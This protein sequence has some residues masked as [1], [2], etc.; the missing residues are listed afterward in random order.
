MNSWYIC[1]DW[2]GEPIVS[3][4]EEIFYLAGE[5]LDQLSLPND[6]MVVKRLFS[7]MV[8]K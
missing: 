7:E 2:M 8:Q 1:E 6:R 5:E 4:A 3:E